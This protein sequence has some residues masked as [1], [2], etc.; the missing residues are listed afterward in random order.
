LNN[1]GTRLPVLE[2]RSV[3]P[4]AEIISFL[5]RIGENSKVILDGDLR[6][7]DIKG[8]NGLQWTINMIEKNLA[9][10]DYSGVVKFTADDI[11]R[12]GL[13]KEWVKA[14]EREYPESK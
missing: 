5:T 3:N 11:V 9:L 13:C 8:M 14:I 2:A 6:Q 4:V 1:L 7:S 12:S 10:Q